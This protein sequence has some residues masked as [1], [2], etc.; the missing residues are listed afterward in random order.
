MFDIWAGLSA[1]D[2]GERF[3][4]D[5]AAVVVAA[6]LLGEESSLEVEAVGVGDDVTA[7]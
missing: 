6:A 2:D 7:F 3:M 5:E 4:E 1:G